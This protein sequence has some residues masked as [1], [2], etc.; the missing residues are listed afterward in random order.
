M[1]AKH[2]WNDEVKQEEMGGE[3]NKNGEKKDKY[4]LVVG[5]PEGITI[6]ETKM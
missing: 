5:K 6:R 3:R 1:S 4:R 2:N